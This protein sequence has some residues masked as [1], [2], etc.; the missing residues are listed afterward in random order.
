[1]SSNNNPNR[2]E[3]FSLKILREYGVELWR[4]D[5]VDPTAF[6]S[7]TKAEH[8]ERGNYRI[9]SR[10]VR[11][12]LV[13]FLMAR[14]KTKRTP[15]KGEIEQLLMLLDA[16]AAAKPPQPVHRRVAYVKA[17]NTIYL[18]LGDTSWRVVEVTADGWSIKERAPV[19]FLRAKGVQPIQA[20]TRAG[21]LDDLKPLLA[22]ENDSDFVLAVSWLLFTISPGGPYPL[23]VFNG[24]QG[25]GKTTRTRILRSFSDPNSA[26]VRRLPKSA[27]DMLIS[28]RNSWI[29]AFDNLSYVPEWFSDGLCCI[30]TGIAEG[31]RTLYTDEDETIIRVKRPVILNGIEE[32]ATR[33]DLIDRSI[34]V[35]T[36]ALPKRLPE[37]KV[38]AMLDDVFPGVLGAILDAVSLGLGRYR[39]VEV[40]GMEKFRMADF[41]RWVVACEPNL[42]WE[43]GTFLDAYATNRSV[44]KATVLDAVPVVPVLVSFLADQ[45]NGYWKGSSTALVGELRAKVELDRKLLDMLPRT[46]KGLVGC[47]NRLGPS[48][49]ECYGIGFRQDRPRDEQGNRRRILTVG[50]LAAADEDEGTIQPRIVP[51]DDDD[52]AAAKVA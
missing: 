13:R 4:D 16:V 18:D 50:D 27:E 48:L 43:S 3:N 35:T 24:E 19:R 9:N 26:P 2:G 5:E 42:P 10:F 52:H 17:T 7:F 40:P 14:S 21:S 47:L 39:E 15:K 37:E 30:S 45:P 46:A 25:T 44:A 12:W 36:T 49:R 33:G 8:L 51:D 31:K 1:M 34:I 20:P 22:F 32:V 29:T 28:A 23:L 41:T 6:L 38:N 11:R